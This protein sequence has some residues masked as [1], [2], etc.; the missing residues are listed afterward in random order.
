MSR[1]KLPSFFRS[2]RPGGG[3]FW[4]WFLQNGREIAAVRTGSE[5][6]LHTIAENLRAVHPNL[7]FEM[8]VADDGL[9]EFIVSAGGIREAIP[10]VEQL[11]ST[12]PEIP[13][14][15]IIA[16][17]QRKQADRIE[18]GGQS[19]GPEDVWFKSESH[20]EHADIELY[21]R[22]FDG[23]SELPL[24]VA[25][26]YLDVLLGEY[27]VMTKI[28]AIDFQPL[29]EDPTRIGLRPIQRLPEVIDSL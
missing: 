23:S 7:Q 11:V 10:A 5:P 22:G 8:S 25:F 17:K 1:M 2:E 16:F 19:F 20:R 21:I 3:E 6:I 28:G 9:R 26:L 15:Q 4:D 13:G 29:P 24:H 14:W 18:I 27:D 12:A